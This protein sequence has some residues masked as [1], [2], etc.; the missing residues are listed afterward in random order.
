MKL[1][2]LIVAISLGCPAWSQQQESAPASEVRRLFIRDCIG[3]GLDYEDSDAYYFCTCAFD[4]LAN[5]MTL[6]EYLEMERAERAGRDPVSLP[7][8]H[9]LVAGL[10]ACKSKDASHGKR[11][12]V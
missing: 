5:G 2:P 6:N 9:R 12:G 4:V 8:V 3:R 1:L 7:Q 11:E 10:E